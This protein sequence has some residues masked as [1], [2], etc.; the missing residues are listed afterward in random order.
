MRVRVD[1]AW[2]EHA[3]GAVY[4]RGI[5]VRA[6]E[7]R[8]RSDGLDLIVDDGN[9]DTG[10]N[11]GVAHL[12]P[13]SRASGPATRYDLCRVDEQEGRGP[14]DGRLGLRCSGGPVDT[15]SRSRGRVPSPESRVPGVRV[16]SH[17]MMSRTRES[18]SG[19][20]ASPRHA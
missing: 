9:G 5:G 2:R 11:S 3:A 7:L 20:C 17:A 18:W 6:L 14:R 8:L 15:L 1:E 13:A 19:A 16:P 4:G 10:H 12:T